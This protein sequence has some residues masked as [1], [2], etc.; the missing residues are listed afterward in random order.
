MNRSKEFKELHNQEDLL[1]IGNVWDVQSASIFEEKGYKAVGTSSAAIATSLGL[2]DGEQMS[3]EQ[4]NEIVKKITSK[5]SIPLTVDI[6]GGYS[7]NVNE[8]I[9]NIVTL[10]RNGV[11][12]IN[13]EDSVVDGDRKILDTEEFGKTISAIKTYLKENKIDLFLNIRTDFFIMGLNN[14]LEETIKRIKTY[15]KYG[16]DGIFVPCITSEQDIKQV[17]ETTTLPINV[18]TMPNLPNFNKLQKLGVK[19]ISMGPFIYNNITDH[20]K[21]TLQNIEKD[22]S[23]NCLF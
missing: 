23:F 11:S 10:Y 2:E 4:L 20:L 12:G 21:K 7:R 16:A 18:M 8:I 1:L 15:E 5:I 22:Q 14:P 9:E 6:E 13:I 17:V 19:R 3:F